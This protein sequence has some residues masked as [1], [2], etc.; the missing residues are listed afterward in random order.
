MIYRTNHWDR[1]L[2][3]IDS[4]FLAY[5]HDLTELLYGYVVNHPEEFGSVPNPS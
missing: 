3:A 1:R 5:P 2:D 4:E